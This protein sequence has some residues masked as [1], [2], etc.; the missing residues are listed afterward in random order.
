MTLAQITL[1]VLIALV[2]VF[3][4]R[5]LLLSRSVTHYTPGE[6][7]AK[8]RNG[9]N[10]VLLDVRTPAERSS[11]HIKGSLHIP[12]QELRQRIQELARYKDREI[13]CYC[14]SGNRSI[15][16]AVALRRQGFDSANMKGGIIEWNFSG[17]K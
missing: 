9:S 8:M 10:P 2:L 3:Y 6:V 4:T 1:L 16:A 5:R 13:I 15:T 11:Q 12:L 7:A 14:R 17:L